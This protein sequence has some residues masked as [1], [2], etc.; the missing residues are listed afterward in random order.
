MG[1]TFWDYAAVF[2][3]LSGILGMGIYFMQQQKTTADYFVGGRGFHW[4]PVAISMFTSLFSAISYIAMPAEAYNHGMMLFLYS[5]A[6][7]LGV[8]PAV[9]IFVRFFRR[10]SL[11]T[12]YEYLERRFDLRVRLMASFLFLLLRSFY[13][14]V[15]LFA[16]GVVLQPAIGWPVWL[17]VV[18]VGVVA[19]ACTTMGGM[20][21]VI[22]ID[23]LQFLVLLGGVVLVLGFLIAEHPDGIS[24][25]WSYAQA[26]DH[27]FNQVW[28]KSFYSLDPFQRISLW[29]V[30]VSAIFQKLGYAGA[31]QISIQRYLSTRSVKDASWSI[32][33]G[34]ALSIPVAFLLYFTGLGLLYYYGVHP[35][36]ALPEMTGDYA[37]THFIS[38]ELPPGVG[39]II[40]AGILAAVIT[41]VCSV[42]NSLSACTITD[43]LFADPDVDVVDITL[44]RIFTRN[45]R[46]VPCKRAST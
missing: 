34:T 32:I 27:T 25:I 12:A 7:L 22:W 1:F 36:R 3:Y 17:S 31:D 35:Q 41:T 20:K 45:T 23:V 21:G 4:L 29:I 26:R 6:M 42:L 19:T 39:G 14:G 24:G 16:S 43:Q 46:F 33:C 28:D 18:V 44:P 9:L 38:S 2:V 11:T 5:A 15:V 40:I 8:L 37:L 30:I 10:L 13:L